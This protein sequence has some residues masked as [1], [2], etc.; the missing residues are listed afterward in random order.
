MQ[1]HLTNRKLGGNTKQ[2][3][4]NFYTMRSLYFVSFSLQGKVLPGIN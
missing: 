4:Q 3:L 1:R 2:T